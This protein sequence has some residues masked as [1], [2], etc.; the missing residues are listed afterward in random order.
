MADK[1]S[2]I[3]KMTQIKEKEDEEKS[4][5]ILMQEEYKPKDFASGRMKRFY[6]EE[7]LGPNLKHMEAKRRV[8]IAQEEWKKN[9][10]THDAPNLNELEKKNTD[11]VP[12]FF[13][14]LKGETPLHLQEFHNSDYTKKVLQR[15]KNAEFDFTQG[16][17][18]S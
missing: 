2:E 13:D 4:K 5:V 17:P 15:M 6:R 12:L 18:S 3:F 11:V 10:D 1:K 7:L 9:W 8:F 14:N 16:P